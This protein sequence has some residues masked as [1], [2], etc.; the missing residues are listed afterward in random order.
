VSRDPSPWKGK[1]P[2]PSWPCHQAPAVQP[3]GNQ[4]TAKL[5]AGN[6]ES[7]SQCAGSRHPSASRG[8]TG[9]PRSSAAPDPFVPPGSN[10]T[11]Q[12]HERRQP[13]S[14]APAHAGLPR[15]EPGRAIPAASAGAERC[16]R[17]R[18]LCRSCLRRSGPGRQELSVRR[19]N[20][21]TPGRHNRSKAV[22]RDA[23]TVARCPSALA[24]PVCGHLR[25]KRTSAGM[26]TV[27]EAADLAYGWGEPSRG[28]SRGAEGRDTCGSGTSG[29]GLAGA[30]AL[31]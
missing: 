14:R 13:F 23:F 30:V 10:P 26:I 6:K 3:G 12:S 25:A 8:D 1:L 15:A 20:G 28:A 4:F 29:R 17:T 5:H 18:R 16:P 31:V 22:F 2:S 7:G 24:N 9:C 19:G 21:G 27:M 11:R